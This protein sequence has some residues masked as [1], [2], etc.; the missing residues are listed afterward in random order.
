MWWLCGR[1]NYGEKPHTVSQ[2]TTH[3]RYHT[4]HSRAQGMKS[5]EATHS[6]SQGMNE[7]RRNL[8]EEIHLNQFEK[9]T[10]AHL[11]NLS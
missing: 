3:T 2:C 1:S 6:L 9:S 8:G 11:R 10:E 7:A 5:R 4:Q